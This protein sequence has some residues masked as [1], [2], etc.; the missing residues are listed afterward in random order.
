MRIDEQLKMICAK[1]D[2]SMAEIARR[3]NQ[4]PQ[5]FGQ[6]VK[7]GNLTIDDLSDIAL[8]SGCQFRCSFVYPNG[9]TVQIL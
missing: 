9:D 5:A 7:R 8:A 3:L 4:S 6:K 1:S 2:L